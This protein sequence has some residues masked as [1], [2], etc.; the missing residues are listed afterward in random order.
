[1]ATATGKTPTRWDLFFQPRGIAIVGASHDLRRIGGQ[2]VKFLST[3]G[4]KGRVY[5]INPKHEEIAGLRC[6]PDITSI[7][8]PCDVA[9]VAVNGTA[10]V[11]VVRECGRKGIRF[12]V[13]FSSGF[14]ETGA[15]G[16]DLEKRLLEAAREH[17]LRIIGPNCQGYL[18]LAERLYATFGV[19]GLEPELKQGPVSSV[20]Q[21][22]GFGFGIVT[23]CESAGVGFRN[24]V[25]SG[26]ESD[27]TTPEL[28][29]AYVQDEGTRLLVGF[30]EG[31]RDGR[32]LMQVAD[33]SLRAGKPL[34]MWKAGNSE[35]GKRASLS[36]TAA[37]TGSYDVYRA[38]YRQ[39]GIIEMRDI[40]EI[41]DSARALLQGRVPRGNRVA[42]LGSSAGSCI[43]FADRC[44]EL[45]LE[46]SALSPETEAELARVIPAYGSPRNP[47][48]VTADVFNDLGAFT[49]AIDLVLA[50][51]RVDQLGVLYAG[52]SGEIALAC[53][54]AVAEAMVRHD[55]PVMLGWT[56]RRNRAE[57]AY[58]LADETGI[59]YFTSPVRLANA[60]E[61]L[62]RFA[63]YRRR[64]VQR[65]SPFA[66][67]ATGIE[68]RFPAK[69]GVLSEAESKAL[70]SSWGI[71]VT[72]DVLVPMGRDSAAL[73]DELRFPLAVKVVSADIAHKTEAG[74]VILGVKDR[75]ELDKAMGE[76]VRRGREYA[77][78]AR[79]DG[80]LVCEM[81]S[82]AVEMLVGVSQDPVFGPTITLGLGGVQAEVMR[83]V[84]Y[85]VAPFDEDTARE[86][87]GELRGVALLQGFRKRPPADIDA[88]A[89][90]VSHLSQVAWALRDRLAE[91][92]INPLMVRPKGVGVVAA[93]ALVVLHEITEQKMQ[94]QPALM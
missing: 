80:A 58:K 9:I 73:V 8:G 55:K 82:D 33:R 85:R 2:P 47:V 20:A 65:V 29:D 17:G 94:S 86:M 11:D 76:V 70:I 36:H 44:A 19:L 57:A 51:P 81:V 14:R 32:A 77:P 59:P 28:L 48:D 40:D 61:V 18:N 62:A 5:P 52:L 12:A 83:D 41:S 79:I 45:G 74:G 30:I 49:K 34:L 7:D 93:D 37:L 46:L 23:Q 87:I 69:G 71:P 10:A 21:S 68:S 75:V 27:V 26:N 72:R 6:Y 38:A 78:Q 35:V 84:A 54:R 25:S 88:L 92:D 13:V 22:G 89:N 39:S 24:I 64:A 56:A 67:P 15:K 16:A 42:A 91:L 66:Q 90:V 4:Y 3:Y 31:V 53:N 1:M 60:T 50:D 43:L 63:Q